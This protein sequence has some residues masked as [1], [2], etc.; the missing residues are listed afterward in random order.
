MNMFAFFSKYGNSSYTLR[1]ETSAQTVEDELALHLSS[2][3]QPEEQILA[4][5]RDNST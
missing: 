3:I 4:V 5:H 1:D 2:H